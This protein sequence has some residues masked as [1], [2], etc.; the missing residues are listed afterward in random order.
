[1]CSKESS[2]QCRLLT[3]RRLLLP[4]SLPIEL[5]SPRQSRL[6]IRLRAPSFR[7]LSIYLLNQ[8]RRVEMTQKD[9]IPRVVFLSVRPLR[10][11]KLIAK[12][13]FALEDSPLAYPL[14]LGRW[15]DVSRVVST[16]DRVDIISDGWFHSKGARR[17]QAI[18]GSTTRPSFLG[19]VKI[20]RW[21]STD[22]H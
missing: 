10:N 14:P 13:L 1:M 22:E 5:L 18:Y 15:W 9:V 19:G 11:P 20:R 6:A 16:G 17:T 3:E 7:W 2:R 21:R 4:L 8:P 12:G